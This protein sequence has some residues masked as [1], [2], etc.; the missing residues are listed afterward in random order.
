MS[1]QDDK[2]LRRA[3]L[4]LREGGQ[5]AAFEKGNVLYERQAGKDARITY[6]DRTNDVRP[7]ISGRLKIPAELRA[8]GNLYGDSVLIGTLGPGKPFAIKT[9]GGKHATG[10]VSLR[11]VEALEVMRIADRAL[12]G[13]SA[14]AHKCHVKT[15]HGLHKPI[16]REV[17]VRGVC[18]YGQSLSEIGLRSGWWV[19]GRRGPHVPPTQTNKLKAALIEALEVIDVAYQAKGIDARGILGVVEAR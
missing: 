8:V 13:M 17:L 10:G 15:S 6:L 18:A 19:Q 16:V 9:D 3:M 12:A 2:A 14:V 5:R 7:L 11:M 1:K 4:K